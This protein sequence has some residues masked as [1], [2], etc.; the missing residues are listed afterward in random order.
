MS[1]EEKKQNNPGMYLIGQI[2]GYIIVAPIALMGLLIALSFI[3]CIIL[4][5][6]SPLILIVL[7]FMLIA[8][9]L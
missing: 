2:L 1:P 7:F 9:A 5:I 4:I 3:V 8:G 6:C